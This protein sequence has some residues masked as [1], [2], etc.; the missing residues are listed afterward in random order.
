MSQS[1]LAEVTAMEKTLPTQ[2]D[3][4]C[5]DGIPMET[6]R[7]VYQINLLIESLHSWLEQRQDGYVGGNMFVYFSSKQLRYQ[8]FRGPDFFAVLGVPK[9]ERKSWVVW[10]EGKSPDVV[11]ELL[12]E[13]TAT[14]DKTDKKQ[15]YQTQL[16]VQEYFWFD[17]FNPK[18]WAGFELNNGRY[19][20]LALDAQGRFISRQ[21][22]LALV[23]WPGVYWQVE[24]TWLRWE[25]LEGTLLP[26]LE[27]LAMK[28]QQRAEQAEQHAARS[29]QCAEQAEQRTQQTLQELQ[30]QRQQ[31]EQLAEKLRA[32]GINPKEL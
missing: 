5:D 9:G 6:Q 21:L 18:D 11:I 8:D 17:P 23:R 16:K 24:T 27:E 14:I 2:D 32:L 10:E 29:K 28:Q 1:I 13:S 30:R 15:I 22:G 3:L 7:H 4:P 19:Q 12:S 31:A 20:T 26:T 25:T